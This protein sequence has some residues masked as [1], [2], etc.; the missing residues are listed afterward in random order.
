MELYEEVL[1]VLE[2]KYRMSDTGAGG[3]LEEVSDEKWEEWIDGY[4]DE[5]DIAKCVVNGD[6]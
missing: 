3:L 2:V 1:N 6:F 4:L 5:Y